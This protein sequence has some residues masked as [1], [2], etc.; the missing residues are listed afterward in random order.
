MQSLQNIRFTVRITVFFIVLL[1]FHRCCSAG[2]L[3]FAPCDVQFEVLGG[4][5]TRRHDVVETHLPDSRLHS[6]CRQ[7]VLSLSLP[8]V[9]VAGRC[10]FDPAA[11]IC[12][13][14]EGSIQRYLHRYVITCAG[15]MLS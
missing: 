7:G 3:H 4:G 13:H 12:L 15:A 1:M 6:V 2:E 11:S 10:Y 8:A 9:R 14:P 5:G